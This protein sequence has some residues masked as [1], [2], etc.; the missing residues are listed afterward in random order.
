MRN[1]QKG[2]ALLTLIIL[3][4]IAVMLIGA[5][6]YFLIK[7]KESQVLQKRYTSSLEAAKGASEIIMNMLLYPDDPSLPLLC[8]TSKINAYNNQNCAIN[9]CSP[10][11]N[12]YICLGQYKCLG[13][14]DLSTCNGG[15]KI[16]ARVLAYKQLITG[17]KI[18]T[19]EVESVYASNPSEKSIIQFVYKITEQ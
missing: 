7:G 13:S 4:F 16:T 3:S 14:A 9:S 18:Y 10:S 8:T 11:S 6:I 15:Y 19:V 17:E 5:L 1:N 12:S 2:L